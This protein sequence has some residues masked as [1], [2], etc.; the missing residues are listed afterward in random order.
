MIKPRL[1]GAR[2][3]EIQREAQLARGAGVDAADPP[4]RPLTPGHH[5][6]F[7]RRSSEKTDIIPCRRDSLQ[8][9][10]SGFSGRL[11]N[12]LRAEAHRSPARFIDHRQR[13]FVGGARLAEAAPVPF[14][15]HGRVIHGAGHV[16]GEHKIHVVGWRQRPKGGV[17]IIMLLSRH[18][19]LGHDI[20]P[21]PLHPA[22]K[23]IPVVTHQ[24]LAG[25]AFAGD[26]LAVL[27]ACLAIAVQKVHLH[28]PESLFQK[29]IVIGGAL[30]RRGEIFQY[31][32]PVNRHALA[33]RIIH[34][35]LHP[36]AILRRAVPNRRP[37][38]HAAVKLDPGPLLFGGHIHK[39]FEPF[40][41]SLIEMV[42]ARHQPRKPRENRRARL[43]PL[44]IGKG[45]RRREIVNERRFHQL[46]ELA[47]GK[48]HPPRRA[49]RQFPLR[50]A[51]QLQL[52]HSRRRIG[53]PQSRPAIRAVHRGLGEVA[54][55][56]AWSLVKQ[57]KLLVIMLAEFLQRLLAVIDILVM[58]EIFPSPGL[59]ILGNPK[60]SRLGEH[61]ILASAVYAVAIGHPLVVGPHDQ[62]EFHLSALA[63]IH[64]PFLGVVVALATFAHRHRVGF[65][66]FGLARSQ[67]L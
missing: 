15:A 62:A 4:V 9:L 67:H 44:R 46:L 23:D 34:Q 41:I 14:D 20:R 21:G 26:I 57:R 63:E 48:D 49:P 64:R 18:A 53:H 52:H 60:R 42:A 40:K 58:R 19:L 8:K 31:F 45:A 6:I 66:H 25:G 16:A 28:P 54:P 65:F 47:D 56:A 59:G 43:D 51:V 61:R 10:R 3:E 55:A 1:E 13:H 36:L 5:R 22:G 24:Q 33:R 17:E 39:L 38:L 12:A 30:L 11:P 7:I 29:E 50:F 35:L 37:T 32:P 27:V 2:F